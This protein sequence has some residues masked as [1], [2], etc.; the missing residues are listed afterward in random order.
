MK[1]MVLML[2]CA[3]LVAGCQTGNMR[4]WERNSGDELPPV[5]LLDDGGSG[6]GGSVASRPLDEGPSPGVLPAGK[7]RFDK[8]PVPLDVREDMDRTYVYES[9]TLQIGRLVYYTKASVV[10][11][12]QFYIRECKA[13]GWQLD[14]VL[15]AEG[16]NL[17]FRKPGL[18]L[19]VMARSQGVG[20][21][22]LLIVSLTPEE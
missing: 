12:A 6:A 4:F 18:R 20:R 14:S 17:L 2:C 22:T 19:D 7:P 15:Q 13:L 1:N 9:S 10:D 21:S 5:E 8:V 11:L 16:A 3:A